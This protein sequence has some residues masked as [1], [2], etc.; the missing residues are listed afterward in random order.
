MLNPEGANAVTNMMGQEQDQ[1]NA[2]NP[3]PAGVEQTAPIRV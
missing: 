3:L 2:E 1:L